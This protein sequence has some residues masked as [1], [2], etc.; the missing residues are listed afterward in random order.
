MSRQKITG[1]K[2][3]PEARTCEVGRGAG[4]DPGS[5]TV[6]TQEDVRKKR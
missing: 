4:G 2:Q 6:E 5:R 1:S 3:G